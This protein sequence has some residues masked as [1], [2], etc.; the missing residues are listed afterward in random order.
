MLHDSSQHSFFDR[1][2]HFDEFITVRFIRVIF[3]VGLA[4]GILSAMVSCIVLAFAG[5]HQM[6]GPDQNTALGL[7]TFLGG[8]L[9]TFF[10]A[11]VG[12]VFWRIYCELLV[13]VFRINDNL[14]ALRD[15]GAG[16]S[17]R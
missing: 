16:D 6:N 7:M 2:L 9:A 13:V 1:F 10:M 12:M 17:R 15:Q 11:I 8:S 3:I 4:F 14:Q 5:Y